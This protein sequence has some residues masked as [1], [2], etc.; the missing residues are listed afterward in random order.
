MDRDRFEK[1]ME[2]RKAVL[3]PEYV[4]ASLAR[5]DDFTRPLQELV[6]EFC[7]GAVWGRDGLERKTRSLINIAMIG[8]LGRNHELELHVG[9][10]FRNGVTEEEIQEVVLQVAVYCGFPAA[11]DTMRTAKAAIEKFKVAE[12]EGK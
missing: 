7:W 9:G 2:V 4:E 5:A 3:S 12:A 10:A 6:T 1:G 8:A 11:I